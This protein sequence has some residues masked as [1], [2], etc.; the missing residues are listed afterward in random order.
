MKKRAPGSGAG[1]EGPGAD[2]RSVGTPVWDTS[3]TLDR[4]RRLPF[5]LL[6]LAL[7][8]TGCNN[9]VTWSCDPCHTTAVVYGSVRDSANASVANVPVSVMADRTAPCDRE[10]LPAWGDSRADSAGEYGGLMG[11]LHGP[12]TARC[13]KVTINPDSTAP[14]PTETFLFQD[15]VQFRA[16]YPGEPRDSIRLDVKLGAGGADSAGAGGA[17]VPRSS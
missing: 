6:L 7:A 17:L 16:E 12:F 5:G 3:A 14:W 13:F 8:L 11:S 10:F 2:D 4:M 15:S 1:P 9:P